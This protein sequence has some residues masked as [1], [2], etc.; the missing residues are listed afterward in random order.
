MDSTTLAPATT[1]FTLE[2]V[3]QHGQQSGRSPE[4]IAGA[5]K[6][7]RDAARS[8][9]EQSLRE[10]DPKK[11]FTGNQ[12]LDARI[13]E[14]LV[15]TQTL[16]AAERIHRA[17]PDPAMR[18]QFASQFQAAE[19]DPAK[20]P[21]PG[22][23][24]LAETLNR[25]VF[26]SPDFD[27]PDA[28]DRAI[29]LATEAGVILG[30]FETQTR[31]E[32]GI[33]ILIRLDDEKEGSRRKAITVP[34]ITAGDIEAAR[35]KAEE[36]AKRL[37]QS[38]NEAKA[39]AEKSETDARNRSP[40][41]WSEDVH[42]AAMAEVGDL[43]RQKENARLKAEEAESRAGMLADPDRGRLVLLRERVEE[44][45]KAD[46]DLKKV[47]GDV[48]LGEDFWRGVQQTHL[49]ARM[50]IADATGNEEEKT[51]LRALIGDLGQIYPGSTNLQFRGGAGA[52]VSDTSAVMGGML[53]TMI[54]S[55]VTGGAGMAGMTAGGLTR[56][57]AL[58]P[59]S[60]SSYGTAYATMLNEA[61]SLEREGRKDEAEQRRKDARSYAMLQA[62]VETGSEFIFK[63][64]M[65][66]VGGK[67]FLRKVGAGAAQNT[68][69]EAIASV[70]NA[71]L[72]RSFRDQLTP[73]SEI[74]RDAAL[75][76]AVG[77]L[78]Q[79]PGGVVEV[80]LPKR[81]PMESAPPGLDDPPAVS[82]PETPPPPSPPPAEEGAP[83]PQDPTTPPPGDEAVYK[84]AGR[85]FTWGENGW[86]EQGKGE[87]VDSQAEPGLVLQLGEARRQLNEGEQPVP[88]EVTLNPSETPTIL[89][90]DGQRAFLPA[91]DG[92]G[93]LEVFP[94]TGEAPR[95][96]NFAS[97]GEIG[98]AIL[99]RLQA[100]MA[101]K[102][103][104]T[105]TGSASETPEGETQPTL[106]PSGEQQAPAE[107]TP[108]EIET[109]SEMQNLGDVFRIPAGQV[110]T[111]PDLMQFKHIDDA[112]TGTNAQDELEGQWDERKAGVLLLWEPSDPSAHGLA[113]GQ[114]FIV[115]NGHHRYAFGTRQGVGS[116]NA[117]IVRETDGYSAEEAMIL[118]A[119]INI[120]DGKGT[121]YDQAKFIRNIA[122]TRGADQAL[123]LAAS[124]GARGKKASRIALD[125]S[126]PLYDAF[127]NERVS[128][129]HIAAIAEAAPGNEGAQRVGLRSALD[130]RPPA[131]AA[132]MARAAV[133]MEGTVKFEQID[134]FGEDD[135]AFRAM[136]RMAEDAGRV[137]SAIQT[138]ITAA[139][140]AA[141]RPDQAREMGIDVAD[142]EAVESTISRLKAD[143]ERWRN[144]P[145]HSDLTQSLREG[146]VDP[147]GIVRGI[148]AE[149][150]SGTQ[151]PP[152]Q[153][154]NIASPSPAVS[155][156][157]E[158]QLIPE[159]DMP[160]NLS[161]EVIVEPEAVQPE[162]TRTDAERD[163]DTGQERLFEDRLEAPRS[164]DA[165]VRRL[166]EGFTARH[167]SKR[168]DVAPARGEAEERHM[169]LVREE[170]DSY[171]GGDVPAG[172][173]V[174]WDPAAV[175]DAAF[176][177][178]LGVIELNAAR[179]RPGEAGFK[180]EHEIG[181][182]LFQ[183]AE[184]VA[185]FEAL[186]S[187][188]P[189]L[190]QE[191]ISRR[192]G[193]S[194][195]K[196]YYA[197]GDAFEETRVRALEAIRRMT[198]GDHA[199]AGVKRAWRQFIA[200]LT[201]AWKRLT[202]REPINPERLAAAM[203][204]IGVARMRSGET[205]GDGVA[206][207]TLD[208]EAF[209]DWIVQNGGIKDNFIQEDAGRLWIAADVDGVVNE[210]FGSFNDADEY[211]RTM[212]HRG[213]FLWDVTESYERMV[214]GIPVR[215][216]DGPIT[217]QDAKNAVYPLEPMPGETPAEVGNLPQ[218]TPMGRPVTPAVL[219]DAALRYGFEGGPVMRR[220]PDPNEPHRKGR[221]IFSVTDDSINKSLPQRL[222]DWALHDADDEI[223]RLRFTNPN[224]GEIETFGDV[225]EDFAFGLS[226]EDAL[227]TV[228]WL[229]A[230]EDL[231]PS[232]R[233]VVS[234][235]VW[236][237]RHDP[238]IRDV[239]PFYSGRIFSVAEEDA[240]FKENVLRHQFESKKAGT[241]PKFPTASLALRSAGITATHITLPYSVIA[242]KESQHEIPIHKFLQLPNAVRNPIMVFESETWSGGRVILTELRH[243][244]ESLAVAI[245][246]EGDGTIAEVRSVH[247][248]P[249][250]Q[251]AR[252]AESGKA[253]YYHQEKSRNWLTQELSPVQFRAVWVQLRRT[254]GIVSDSDLQGE[255]FS[256]SDGIQR[257]QA[258]A[259]Q[260]LANL[261]ATFRASFFAG[262]FDG[263]AAAMDAAEIDTFEAFA[264]KLVRLA[265]AG[266]PDAAAMLEWVKHVN[267]G[268][269]PQVEAD[270]ELDALL[271]AMRSRFPNRRRGRAMMDHRQKHHTQDSFERA[272][273]QHVAAGDF[274]AAY[275]AVRDSDDSVRIPALKKWMKEA[276]KGDAVAQKN[277]EWISA[278]FNG[279][280]PPGVTQKPSTGGSSA[281]PPQ[282]QQQAPPPPPPPTAPKT[283][284]P[285]PEGVEKLN[286]PA[287]VF[288]ARKMGTTP[289][290]RRFAARGSFKPSNKR[291]EH[292]ADPIIRVNEFLAKEDWQQAARTL[293][294]EIGHFID[295]IVNAV[296]HA[297][298]VKRLVP[299]K[300][301]REQFIEDIFGTGTKYSEARKYMT[302]EAV[303]I[304]K[305]MRGDFPPTDSYRNS[306][307]E[308]YADFMSAVMIDPDLA[309]DTAPLLSHAWFAHLN[310]KPGA[311]SA[312][313]LVQDLIKGDALHEAI[314]KDRVV[315]QRAAMAA[316]R[317]RADKRN[318]LHS[319]WKKIRNGFA[320]AL[321][322]RYLPAAAKGAT[323]SG[324]WEFTKRW[325]EAVTKPK[326]DDFLAKM[327][328]AEI[329]A[330]QR[331]SVLRVK[332]QRDVY[333]PLLRHGIDTVQLD[334][335][336]TFF[337][338]LNE[339][340]ATRQYLEANP[341]EFREFLLWLD[342][343][344][345]LD[346]AAEIEGAA[347]SE[348]DQIGASMVGTIQLH[349]T[350]ETVYAMAQSPDAPDIA[351]RG[352]F[353]FDIARYQWNQDG[354]TP[355]TAQKGMDF[356]KRELGDERFNV[357][358][359]AAKSFH[360]NLAGIVREA[361]DVGL[362]GDRIWAEKI[363]PNIGNYVPRMVLDYFTGEMSASIKQR[364]GSV[365]TT[366]PKHIAGEGQAMV[367]LHKIAKQ[368]QMLFIL[369]QA[370][371][372]G[373]SNEI[374]PIKIPRGKNVEA[375]ANKLRKEE[376]K[377]LR[378]YFVKGKWKWMVFDD[379]DVVQWMDTAAPSDLKFIY[380][381]AKANEGF[382]RLS[383]TVLNA[384]FALY[385]NWV[386]TAITLPM[387]YGPKAVAHALRQIPEAVSWARASLGL[388]APS[389]RVLDLVE[390]GVLPAFGQYTAGD[391][392]LSDE[393][394]IDQI[395]SGLVGIDALRRGT[396]VFGPLE[397]VTN[398][399]GIRQTIQFLGLFT[400]T[401]EAL[402]KLAVESLLAKRGLPQW[403]R[404]RLAR[405]E[406]IPNTGLSAGKYGT[407]AGLVSL[408]YRVWVQGTRRLATLPFNPR[409]RGMWLTGNLL[410]LGAIKMFYAAAAAGFLD[411][412]MGGDDEEKQVDFQ[413]A[414]TRVPPYKIRMTDAIFYGW[415][416]PDGSY[417]VPWGHTSIPSDWRPMMWRLPFT[418]SGRATA[419]LASLWTWNLWDS[420]LNLKSAEDGARQFRDVAQNSILPSL[421][422][423]FENAAYATSIFDPRS[424]YDAY[425]GKDVV[426]KDEWDAGIPSR[427]W[428]ITK[429]L[430][431]ETPLKNLA[432]AVKQ[433]IQN[434]DDLPPWARTVMSLPGAS[435]AI[436][437][438]NSHL[439]ADYI[440]RIE[441]RDSVNREARL[442]RGPKAIEAVSLR[443][444]LNRIPA[445]KRT[446]GEQAK[447][448]L[449][450][451]WYRKAY[452]G[453]DL[454][455]GL[456]RELQAAAAGVEGID[457]KETK[458]ALEETAV[459]VLRAVGGE[460]R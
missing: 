166:V 60:L 342:D 131:F 434:E 231:S 370:K 8:W 340:T 424:P 10:K 440:D 106:P 73:L 240:E 437:F 17:L 398:L 38:E 24:S 369:E 151:E 48:A 103:A 32:G 6:K 452:L 404:D 283:P 141:R 329:E 423:V 301:V 229:T 124:I 364:R 98:I 136:E 19:G 56:A 414:F 104:A 316:V 113:D 34:E 209:T 138:R 280:L 100:K 222:A 270:P 317:D 62:A 287:L 310:Q 185:A 277:L 419:P 268:T 37:R 18:E 125:A 410:G 176:D 311:E 114:K 365:K 54:V 50:A 31:P 305:I 155:A 217:V 256:L 274:Q 58:A 306:A 272:F 11:W 383:V 293:A 71:E 242:K 139:Q 303:A 189:K 163:A 389:D 135:S 92:K 421:N 288:L 260:S 426:P 258:A 123:A 456:F 255:I 263:S 42:N 431:E 202:G 284:P 447:I 254:K 298:I 96:A 200:A 418:E 245:H 390:R 374:Q 108:T 23:R 285:R 13:R 345:G 55:T 265:S 44:Q 304:S 1:Q 12:K 85:E 179:L 371:D 299:L 420:P 449:L 127:V 339:D 93:W 375:L 137:Q 335:Y 40:F 88:Q 422:P 273:A 435:A 218:F 402:P 289:L 251:F 46:K 227:A 150:E 159:G 236:V 408:F 67:G 4:E 307:V 178:G 122:A 448:D 70:G 5:V 165:E 386:R 409:T 115:A 53:P 343:A 170:V 145:M 380:D 428:G 66:Q 168:R 198:A 219:P 153:E 154:R 184:F 30:D 395:S 282:A 353:A 425:S 281:T 367:L 117:Q 415:L 232:A 143:L 126:N 51:K 78:M 174:V 109:V 356:L 119:E 175:W 347:D 152:R 318:V 385:N 130:G 111:R 59:I 326:E 269:R 233:D 442:L 290:V 191:R 87:P 441:E 172:V 393:D 309:F 323:D 247:N 65:F 450:N 101:E 362:F 16:A 457:V 76:T 9:G 120:A 278:I 377:G 336:L 84:V 25:E 387:D 183:D 146:T 224:T 215:K 107:Q 250:S 3:V 132:N 417:E 134:L 394:L 360:R 91:P 331:G 129:D 396:R 206:L 7:W 105:E 26:Q 433:G 372:A 445:E 400:G 216:P 354:H 459:E 291:G 45:V 266:N 80:F 156:E 36:E 220:L 455:P 334:E 357:L 252:F 373:W 296:P 205:E 246:L 199:D 221:R 212:S 2:E 74:A 61:D 79:V 112:A 381:I 324:K 52:F 228:Q 432:P 344:A 82:D 416:L 444:R 194:I 95:L 158:G 149:E 352:L 411:A 14:E 320:G 142:P 49:G 89:T 75:G 264:R 226:E 90:I 438:D 460:G 453:S 330:S 81:P 333:D 349:E 235:I 405:M 118:A 407:Y 406:G 182:L 249:A 121:I 15:G 201:R 443:S 86:T 223:R 358:R 41:L 68:A 63:E 267:A 180:I 181:H 213:E 328:G 162:D 261:E 348:L 401:A 196:G 144:W 193:K 363:A 297:D 355:E 27:L 300:A 133:A 286:I 295:Y 47:V 244:G 378:G 315:D 208:F 187:A 99:R 351:A 376:R 128:P 77:G 116:F 238:R 161:G 384:S 241:I 204:E 430:L 97:E 361:N 157:A 234:D 28:R 338:I 35:A 167:S 214:G 454:Y 332:M 382:W 69:E 102:R 39:A 312:W 341:E 403:E 346:R 186:W 243:K 322:S 399:P 413:E 207:S 197:E 20:M 148:M 203:I 43:N 169:R 366:L 279:T 257:E 173:R 313:N 225:A 392:L 412:L 160:F 436:S 451:E 22:F 195:E 337:Q 388:A 83:P 248:R 64:E 210:V 294:H 21:E 147:E 29:P 314:R 110:V 164:P 72:D 94:Q 427:A 140:S 292:Q 211:F 321:W 429:H 368:K 379:I 192:V 190:Q 446:P 237:A 253:L 33:D 325:W 302:E 391:L 239:V 439:A 259:A 308:L 271:R 327:E 230:L 188:L 350:F 319:G 397:K 262:D 359:D 57:A 275:E 458:K 276:R 171:F 177:R